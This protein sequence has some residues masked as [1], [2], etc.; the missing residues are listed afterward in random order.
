MA[1]A[2]IITVGSELLRGEVIDTHAGWISRW[3]RERGIE[4]VLHE[5][6]GDDEAAIADALERASRRASLL[7]LTGGLGPT[8]D[9]RT[10]AGLARWLG[11]P[12][13]L[14]PA[15]WETIAAWYRARGRS[16][17]E[18]ARRQALV[19]EGAR[20][21]ANP[22]GSAPALALEHERCRIYALPGV[23]GE[24]RALFAGPL[25]DEIVRECGH[26]VI[27]TARLRT[28]GLPEPEVDARL[29]SLAA[30]EIELGLRVDGSIV[31][32]VLTARG[33]DSGATHERLEAARAA[34]R[35][36]LG[37]HVFAEGERELGAV[38]LEALRARGWRLAFAESCTAGLAAH[39]LARTPGAS[40]V[41]LGGVVAYANEV[42]R[43][44]LGV[45]SEL[46]ERFG[47]VS[48]P[49][50]WAM[51]RGAIERV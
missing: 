50:A 18:R 2:A 23:P 12:L 49:V 14:D 47:A 28:V 38:V 24:L 4:V 22:V 19:P 1:N 34:A 32:V 25:G 36:A 3:L 37:E 35:E 43:R 21:V 8:D 33:T 40:D 7:L 42:K 39:L 10:R 30:L 15:A 29:R 51:A 11:R 6:V 27:A 26:D 44:C 31:D 48:E 9:D 46:L 17:D 16:A 20:A 5:S 13:R 41:L 45:P